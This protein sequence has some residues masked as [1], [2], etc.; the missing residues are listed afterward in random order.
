MSEIVSSV[1]APEPRAL[2]KKIKEYHPPLGDRSGIR[3]DFNEN[4]FA[5]SPKVLDALQRVTRGDLTRYPER[6]P[7]EAIVAAKLGIQPS[8]ALLTNGVDE[9][10]HVLCQAY[11]DKDDELLLPVPTYTMYGVYA[12]A[13]E[14]RLVEVPAGED[15][16]FP[17][18]ALLA[19]I[20]PKTKLIAIANPNSPTGQVI[21]REDIL[22]VVAAVP[23]AMVLIDEAYYHFYGQSVMDLVGRVPNVIVARTFSKV[24][25]LAG[26]RLGLLA[27]D[28]SAMQWLRRVISPYS[29]NAL[30]LACLPPALEDDAYLDWY[31]NEVRQAREKFTVALTRMGVR[32][33]PSQANF[34]LTN[35]G[36]KHAAFSKAMHARG[37]LVRDR[38]SDPGCDGCV[39]ITIGTREHTAAGIAAM[40]AVLNEIEWTGERA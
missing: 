39:R 31:V 2:V 14:G 36:A 9:A 3:L 26:L 38:S 27:A 5:C 37:V 18:E 35:I 19:R 34:V 10:I 21:S 32:W 29:V 7:V 20:T 1:A 30:A 24:Y 28:E 25:G 13:T 15:F 12:S 8:Q 4:T 16:Q 23:H 40:E 17:L 11:L 6:T 22:K 33:W